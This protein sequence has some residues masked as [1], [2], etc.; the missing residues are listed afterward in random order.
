MSMKAAQQQNYDR[1]ILDS[2]YR[3]IDLR[4]HF[5]F[6]QC[7]FHSSESA[8]L[9]VVPDRFVCICRRRRRQWLRLFPV[10]RKSNQL[11]WPTTTTTL[12]QI[13][14]ELTTATA[15]E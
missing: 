11:P 6:F 7:T 13:A 3:S 5:N 2:L 9:Y 10:S 8:Q 12:A 14:A 1:A 4:G 15:H